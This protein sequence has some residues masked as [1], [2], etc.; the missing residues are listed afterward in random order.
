MSATVGSGTGHH[1]S[2]ENNAGVAVS[3]DRRH[4]GTRAAT[5]VAPTSTHQDAGA[6]IRPASTVEATDTVP[7]AHHTATPIHAGANR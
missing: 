2:V 4:P 3:G 7:N 5:A 1:G 6:T